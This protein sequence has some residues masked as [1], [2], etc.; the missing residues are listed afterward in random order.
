MSL[1]STL[2][3]IYQFKHRISLTNIFCVLEYDRINFLNILFSERRRRCPEEILL[4]DCTLQ[5]NKQDQP[6]N[7]V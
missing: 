3:P 2:F 1:L 5:N 4:N 6:I 7:G